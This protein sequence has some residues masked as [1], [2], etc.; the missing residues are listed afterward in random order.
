MG[1]VELYPFAD[2][3]ERGSYPRWI[4]ELDGH[5]GVYI[6]RARDT[7][8]VVYVGESHS[9][10]LYA[11]L[12]R[13]FQRWTPVH[14]TA[15]PTY[16]RDQVEVA[17]I[18]TPSDHAEYMQNELICVL[19]PRDNRLRCNE[20]F[21]PDSERCRPHGYR[22]DVPAIVDGLFYDYQAEDWYQAQDQGEDEYHDE[23]P[24]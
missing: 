24:F 21:A 3:G 9:D 2:M 4:R 16:D 18:L 15:G 8:E 23:V 22:Y 10:R 13:H 20:L 14:N 19:D 5:N 7:G 17:V 12:T 6:I 1:D 11:T